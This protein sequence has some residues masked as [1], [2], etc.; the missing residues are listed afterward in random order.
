MI[1][2]TKAQID[3]DLQVVEKVKLGQ[4]LASM[5]FVWIAEA[6]KYVLHVHAK[7]DLIFIL[8]ILAC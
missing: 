2:D 5:L 3:A 7:T 8:I 1:F 4:V 6:R